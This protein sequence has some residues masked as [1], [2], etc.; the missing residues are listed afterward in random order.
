MLKQFSHSLL[1]SEELVVISERMIQTVNSS[2]LKAILEKRIKKTTEASSVLSEALTE[3]LSNVYAS[4]VQQADLLRDDAFQAFKYGVLSASYRTE[5]SIKQAGERLVEVVRKRGFSLYNLGYIA[6]SEAMRSLVDDL[7]T[8]APEIS[9]AGVADLLEEMLN[10]HENFNQV[11]HDK[12]NDGSIGETPQVVVWKT[13]LSKQITLFL[14]HVELL[15]ED[16][17][18]GI[19][20]LV[21]KL[22]GIISDMMQQA[23]ERQQM[24]Q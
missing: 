17:E 11:Y 24:A 22:N 15:E 4:R 5:P 18:E 6:Q 19:T 2:P 13:E 20:D 12:M 16:K 21:N 14:N 10:A 3:S 1:T 8:L 7:N 9:Y 23:Q